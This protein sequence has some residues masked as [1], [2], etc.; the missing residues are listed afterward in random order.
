MLSYYHGLLS[1]SF[2]LFFHRLTVRPVTSARKEKEEETGSV[3]GGWWEGGNAGDSYRII[4]W[5]VFVIRLSYSVSDLHTAPASLVYFLQEK[6][7]ILG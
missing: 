7:G 6:L 5:Q 3:F 2:H 4:S 1:L